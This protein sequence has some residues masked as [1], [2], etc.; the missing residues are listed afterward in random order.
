VD[1]CLLRSNQ[2]DN[3][4][5]I[6][7]VDDEPINIKVVEKHL[8]CAGY[9][10]FVTTHDSREALDVIRSKQPDVV[11]LDVMMPHVGGLEIL[12]VI[13]GDIR[14]HHLPVLILTAS[15]DE[16]TRKEA[17]ESGATDFLSK[18]VQAAELVPRVRN[19]LVVKAHHDNLANQSLRLER[20]VRQR[21]RELQQSRE[22]VIHV[23]ACAAEYRDKETGNHVLRVGR[24]AEIIARALGFH[25]SRAELIGQA[26]V[27]HDVG[28]IG[29]S[30]TILLKPG[31]LDPE[32]IEIMKKHCR[33]GKN[34]L[35]GMP[36]HGGLGLP[37]ANQQ[38]SLSESPVLKLAA[39]I[40]E[41]HHERWDGSG[42][43]KGLSGDAIPIEG[44]IMAVADVFD[45]LYSRR[46]Y[47]APLPEDRCFEILEEGR[48]SQF[49]P[50][51]LDAFFSRVDDI[52]RIAFDLADN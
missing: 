24:Y 36:S 5:T 1:E 4:G 20:E 19:A 45:A 10:S 14:L 18:P 9:D 27:L 26:A 39:V 28:K 37:G 25:G 52:L 16:R 8:R 32:E 30:D 40:A 48:G 13:R 31:K 44:R 12:E 41:S 43:P 15:S 11:L 22:E 6:M 35:M 51:V 34:I 42:Y 23:L 47:K 2:G 33:Y 7:I 17:L 29:I 38:R 3:R 50:R 21:T 46:P 49:D